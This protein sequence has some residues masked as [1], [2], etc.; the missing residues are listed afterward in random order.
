VAASR[1]GHRFVLFSALID[2]SPIYPLFP[3]LFADNGLSSGQIG[4]LL[5]L[6]SVVTLLVDVP[7]GALADLVS[8]RVVLAV[9]AIANAVACAIWVLYPSF[10]IFAAG[11]ALW[12]VSSAFRVGTL[13]ALVY[14]ELAAHGDE[15]QYARW[16]SLAHVGALTA[17]VTAV[18]SAAPLF[19]LA[20][21]HGIGL[22]SAGTSMLA[23]VVAMSFPA[24]RVRQHSHGSLRAWLAVLRAGVTEA[25][26]HPRVR[27]LVLLYAVVLGLF[28]FE[29]FFPL[30]AAETGV[31]R[32][33]VPLLV[34]ATVLGPLGGS[35]VARKRPS[36]A[37]FGI[38]MGIAGGLLAMGSLSGAAWG[39]LLIG[40]GIGFLQ[41]AL[42]VSDIALQ[43]AVVG[44]NRATVS[45]VAGLAG[46][47][48]TVGCYLGWGAIA[49]STGAGAALA[50]M[51]L[52]LPLLGWLSARWLRNGRSH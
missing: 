9:A 27:P 34:L 36:R 42:I 7:S 26:T 5:A 30:I 2:L 45:S 15:Q 31:P 3:V 37:V 8:R 29:E 18:L 19:A 14:D 20:G 50:W 41:Y 28:A 52:P 33:A 25:T 51:C 49:N 1:I 6:W 23:A 47:V 22:V 4:Q 43:H 35:V 16:S 44:E 38:G 39:F 24:T 21:Y 10:A 12:G 46:E 32:W 11:S 40:A 48:A 17:N 13:E